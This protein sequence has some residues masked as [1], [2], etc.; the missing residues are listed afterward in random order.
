MTFTLRHARLYLAE[1]YY[2]QDDK[3]A[4]ANTF[5]LSYDGGGY[6]SSF[7][8]INVSVLATSDVVFCWTFT[9]ARFL[10]NDLLSSDDIVYWDNDSMLGIGRGD[11]NT[12]EGSFVWHNSW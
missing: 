12:D 9:S 1:S 11:T 8:D 2:E 4:A 6:S 10:P 3:S 7:S 5:N